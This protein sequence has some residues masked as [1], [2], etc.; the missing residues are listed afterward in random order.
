MDPVSVCFRL[1]LSITLWRL[2]SDRRVPVG[3]DDGIMPL[4]SLGVDGFSNGFEY[5]VCAEVVAFDMVSTEVS[6]EMATEL[7]SGG[8]GVVLGNLCVWM[9]GRRVGWSGTRWWQHC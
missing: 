4:P 8:C 9:G 7:D 6:T 3:V 2:I 5:L 1:L